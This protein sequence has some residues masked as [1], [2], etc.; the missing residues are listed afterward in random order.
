MKEIDCQS[1]VVDLVRS[2]GGAATKL[3]NRFLVGVAD[4]LV[5]LPK[6]PATLIEVKLHQTSTMKDRE[7]KLEVTELQKKFLREYKAAGFVCGVMSFVEE[8]GRGRLGLHVALFEL[9]TIEAMEYR[10]CLNYHTSIRNLKTRNEHLVDIM[11][12]VCV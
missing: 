2:R 7:F 11:E 12:E 10:V 1:M 5:K 6:W 8:A 4:L 3:S 9:D